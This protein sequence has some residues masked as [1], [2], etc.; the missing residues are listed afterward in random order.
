MKGLFAVT[1]ACLLVLAS[2]ED[3][4]TSYPGSFLG[5]FS[6]R[7]VDTLQ[8][9]VSRGTLDL[10]RDDSKVSGHWRFEDGRSGELDGVATNGDLALNLN[11]SYVD[12]NLLLQ[13]ALAG[14][15]FSGN[16]EQIGFPGVMDRGTFVATRIR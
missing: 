14:D 13:G 5:T 2:C 8:V 7:A 9:E 12:N 11:P 10:F 6:F 15:I 4:G 3:Y 1:C 16:W